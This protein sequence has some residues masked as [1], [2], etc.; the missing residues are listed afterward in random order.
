MV[1]ALLV[2]GRLS[3][4]ELALSGIGAACE[5]IVMVE[6]D[7]SSETIELIFEPIINLHFYILDRENF[8]MLY[9]GAL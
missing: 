9:T 3:A 7:K 1:L 5:D 4:D 6:R 8:I 2:S